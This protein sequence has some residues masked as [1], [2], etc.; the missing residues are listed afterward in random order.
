[1][2]ETPSEEE[3]FDI[4]DEH[5]QVLRSA[6]RS[7]V[8]GGG[9]LHRA[10]HIWVINSAGKLL[11]HLRAAGKE[12][13]PLKWTSSASGHVSAGEAYSVSAARELSEELGIEAQLTR[14]HKIM[15]GPETGYEHT[16]LYACQSDAVPIPDPNEISEI[17]YLDFAEIYEWLDREPTAFTHPFRAFLRWSQENSDKIVFD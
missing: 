17:Q 4:V 3:W 5:D 12:E 15:S 13:E 10:T 6:P 14:W 16:E 7:E 1:M 9:H 2:P 11:I 8:H